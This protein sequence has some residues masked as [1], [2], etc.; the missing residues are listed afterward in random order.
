MDPSVRKRYVDAYV[1]KNPWAMSYACARRRCI[2]S[3]G[4][5]DKGIKFLMTVKDFEFLW[6]R[7]A[8]HAMSKPSIDRIDPDGNYTLDNCRF[9]EIVEN[10]ARRRPSKHWNKSHCIN[11]H[12]MTSQNTLINCE[13]HRRCRI[14]CI[15]RDR[16]YRKER[17]LN[18]LGRG[19]NG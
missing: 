8:A 14:C 4:Y 17:I 3:K 13:G 1:K 9:I 12:G 2:R 10:V 7:D 11:G 18:K 15:L 5:V 6:K 19:N 16:R